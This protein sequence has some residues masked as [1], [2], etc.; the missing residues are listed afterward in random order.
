[1]MAI[2]MTQRQVGSFHTK[3]YCYEGPDKVD[4]A[5]IDGADDTGGTVTLWFSWSVQDVMWSPV[6][7]GEVPNAVVEEH[8]RGG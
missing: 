5:A 3:V 2:H 4:Y 7:E 6:R 1:M 8:R